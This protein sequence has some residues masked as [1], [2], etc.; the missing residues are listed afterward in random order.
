MSKTALL[1]DSYVKRLGRFCD[2]FLG[3]SGECRFYG[4][5]GMRADSVIQRVLCE[6]MDFHP[7]TVF[8]CLG[9]NDI[10]VNSSPRQTFEDI[11]NVVSILS[12]N[13]HKNVYISEI[14]TR[15]QFSKP[16]GLTK[17]IFDK[18]G[19]VI[20]KQL[21]KKY[22]RFFVTFSDIHFPEHYD[23]DKVHL[24]TKGT[25]KVPGMKKFQCRFSRVLC[26]H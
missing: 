21:R 8:V 2:G 24:N 14:I 18:K 15:G 7:E 12:E 22:G 11:V 19:K 20:N 23:A 5:G 17:E 4:V 3:I 25:G 6:L 26:R 10:S 16:P 1:R 9:G 13:G